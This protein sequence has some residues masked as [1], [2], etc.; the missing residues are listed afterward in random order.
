MFDLQKREKRALANWKLFTK[1]LLIKE[2][3]KKRFDLHEKPVPPSGGDGSGCQ[4]TEE[5]KA[6]DVAQSWPLNRETE[7]AAVKGMSHKSLFPSE[8]L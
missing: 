7:N 8:E 4:V 1:S 2:R 5:Q 6:C 3:L